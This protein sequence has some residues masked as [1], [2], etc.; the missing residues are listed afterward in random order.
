MLNLKFNP[1]AIYDTA[2][3]VGISTHALVGITDIKIRFDNDIN[4]CLY[5]YR[6]NNKTKYQ[7]VYIDILENI[8]IK[9]NDNSSERI[10]RILIEDPD[11]G[12]II[13]SWINDNLR[14]S[15]VYSKTIGIENRVSNTKLEGIQFSERFDI[16]DIKNRVNKGYL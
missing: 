6:E 8:N 13:R 15:V 7:D 1:F 4:N 9:N 10:D 2:R 16:E 5:L 12:I 3:D 14:C 11:T